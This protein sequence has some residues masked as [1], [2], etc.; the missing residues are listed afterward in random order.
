MTSLRVQATILLIDDEADVRA[1][2]AEGLRLHGYQVLTAAHVP[3][4]DAIGQRLGLEHLALVILDLSWTD[5]PQVSEGY[6]LVQRWGA[7]APQLPFILIS[8]DRMP[9]RLDPPVVW[10]LAK[11]LT[12]DTLLMAVCDSLGT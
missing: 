3:E 8:D 12:L 7:Q 6:T 5:D 11:P 2:R 4:A 9:D 10:W 1:T